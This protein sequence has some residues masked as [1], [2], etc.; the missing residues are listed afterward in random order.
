MAQDATT[1][2]R[3]F[4]RY[5]WNQVRWFFRRTSARRVDLS[6]R[7]ASWLVVAALASLGAGVG[8]Y[9]FAPKVNIIAVELGGAKQPFPLPTNTGRA[10][11]WDAALIAGY[12]AFLV[13]GVILA[14]AVF[15]TPQARALARLAPVL[16]T[17]TVLADIGENACIWTAIHYK[18]PSPWLNM[19]TSASV[20]KFCCVLP[21]AV[22]ATAGVVLSLGRL[23]LNRI[24]PR[25]DEVRAE[26]PAP[27]E[28]DA[29]CTLRGSEGVDRTRWR[30]AFRVPDL[31]DE[32]RA[33]IKDGKPTVGI[34]L[35]GGG[36]RSASVALGAVQT[37]RDQL[38]RA[39]YLVSVSG[40]GYTAG[41]LQLAL[42]PQ[43]PDATESIVGAIERD[44][45]TALMPGSVEEDRIRRHANYLADSPQQLLIALGVVARVVLVSL[46]LVFSTA[47]VAGVIAGRA[48]MATPIVPWDPAHHLHP[49]LAGIHFPGIRTGTWYLLI[50]LAAGA[51]LIYLLSLLVA[52]FPRRYQKDSLGSRF[53]RGCD[54]WSTALTRLFVLVTAITV[55]VPAII[56]GA[57]YLLSHFGTTKTALG[58]SIGTVLLTY[59][60]TLGALGRRGQVVKTTKGLFSRKSGVGRAVPSGALRLLLAIVTLAVLAGAWLLLY[61]GFAAVAD[62]HDTV[63]VA[64]IVLVVLVVLGLVLDQTE[65]SLHPF[66]RERL[67][68]AFDARRI[69][70]PDGYLAAQGY[71][72]AE[73]TKLS[74]YGRRPEG[75]PEVIFAAAANLTGEQRAPLSAASFTMTSEWLGGPDV[76]YM[77]TD[78]IERAVRGQ[79]ERDLT[80]E[81]AVAVSGAAVASAMG[82]ASRWYGTLLA[83]SGVRLGTWLPNP[84]FVAEWSDAGSDVWYRPRI[85]SVRRLTYLVREILGIHQSNDRLLQITDGGHYENLGLVELLRRR[86]TEIYCIDASGDTPPTA[87]TL[88][89]AIALAKAELGVEIEFQNDVWELVPGSASKL[90]PEDAL[91]DLNGRLSE[92]AVVV[93]K[94]VYPAESL[95]PE[96]GTHPLTGWLVVAKALLTRDMDYDLLSY[97]TRNAAFPHDS[98]GDQF[99]DD[100]KFCAYAQ[101]G[102]ELGKLAAEAMPTVRS[103]GTFRQSERTVPPKIPTVAESLRLG[104]TRKVLEWWSKHPRPSRTKR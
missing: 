81:A 14:D 77:R 71:G 91:S 34:C 87:G 97:A 18:D 58:S 37:L 90:K 61:G 76:G 32:L 66:Y 101:L 102:R 51:F 96:L 95:P 86:C 2:T 25:A 24:R 22:V 8:L 50:A 52:V 29:A 63:W 26:P 54:R 17:A 20:L 56:F 94:I 82:R 98:T 104:V 72:F 43:D 84:R 93:A 15:W 42:T 74:T 45:A 69:K 60:A 7:A 70:R 53:A 47:V 75:F 62:E 44:P 1:P 28:D 10:L 23:V 21:A 68:G 85:P 6:P 48:Y 36:V 78:E 46:A 11:L 79:M 9:Q 4:V 41:A 12:G 19:A 40:G 30:R 3:R 80:V 39:R 31:D 16:A 57:A 49:G 35:S 103:D 89:D 73:L 99:F 65:L 67:A 88:A 92:S 83:L 59:A 100:D 38:L 55:A 33:R 5:I 27:L 13:I 64:S